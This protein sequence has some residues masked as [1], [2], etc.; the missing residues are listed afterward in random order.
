MKKGIFKKFLTLALVVAVTATATVAGTLAYLKTDRQI[1]TNTFQ[2]GKLDVEL[3][4]ETGVIGSGSVSN[5]PNGAEYTK[6][7]PGDKIKKQ[8]TISNKGDVDS[9]V[10]VTVTLKN[11]TND[12]ASRLNTAIDDVYGDDAA[13]GIY[14]T[15][16][17]GWGLNHGKDLDNDGINDAG[18]RLTITGKDMPEHVLQVDM[19]KT[20]SDYTQ[21]YN[22]NWFTLGTE[23]WRG[24][25]NS[26]YS[27]D[28]NKAAGLMGKY[29]LRYTYYID[30]PAGES[31]TLFNG[32][33]IPMDFTAEQLNMFDGL[34]V[35]IQA[36][37]IQKTGFANAKSA[38]MSMIEG[39]GKTV[40][41]AWP[42]THWE[43]N[44]DTQWYTDN[45]DAT[46]YMIDTA[47]ELAGLSSLVYS[48]N[49]FANKTI[50]LGANI[51]LGKHLWTPIGRMINTSGTGE[52]ST[53]K[54]NF[55]G[56]G[57]TVSNLFIDTVDGI[58]GN[59]TNKGAGLFGAVT[60]SIDGLTVTNANIR[61]AHWAGA[62]AGSIEGSITNCH[63]Y[64]VEIECLPEIIDNEYDNNKYDNGDK[65]GA[66]VGY[67]TDGEIS[68]CT[69]GY[70][71]ITGYRNLGGIVGASYNSVL[72]SKV[73]NLV[74]T[75]NREHNYKTDYTTLE[76]YGV[77]SIIGTKYES[78]TVDNAS[79]SSNVEIYWSSS[80][81]AETDKL[82]DQLKNDN[83]PINIYLLSGTHKIPNSAANQTLTIT[84][85]SETIIEIQ[86]V[87]T[88]A[89]GATLNF[90]GVTIQ[91]QTSGDY[92][93]WGN[94]ANVHFNNCTINGK[95]AMYG[96]NASFVDCV[97]NNKND[98]AV[99]TWGAEDI[100][101][102]NCTFNSGGKALLVYGEYRTADVLI[103]KCT[104]NDDDTLNNE[105]AAI[106]IGSDRAIDK[107]NI[108]INEIKVNGFAINPNGISTN[109]NIWANK[110][111]MPTDR[112]NV[113]IDG[114]DVY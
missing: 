52:D 47:E 81:N 77:D 100:E 44:I 22:G 48:G 62:I 23:E 35:D 112:L 95:I 111:S 17:E 73:D 7:I 9:Y 63:V 84:G 1:Q 91:G 31:T 24:L 16:F 45:P 6:L 40:V 102:V 103:D 39:D 70:V 10:R 11:K 80:S 105:K 58:E 107:Y 72:N 15:V 2:V 67:A 49:N 90:N 60:G 5:Q 54:G 88:S 109:S 42:T 46:N 97:F 101:F 78:A 18:V 51:D 33:N 68:N 12:F 38:F 94:G 21:N 86:S 41:E 55:D 56:N 53:F 19:T 30:L 13:Q 110:N 92:A 43:E 57:Y 87:D 114:V 28:A 27:S 85:T 37:G 76:E 3:K 64:D 89:G 82:I 29:E 98:Y 104:F 36:D 65:A 79:T 25:N 66:I 8:V 96:K 75:V 59:D 71:R 20:I 34:I 83:K 93:G 26:Y 99:W 4:E 108:V 106:E 74:I 69:A 14:N 32:F 113:V 50:E 61:T